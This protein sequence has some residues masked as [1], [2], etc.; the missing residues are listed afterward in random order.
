MSR[1]LAVAAATAAAGVTQA[2]LGQ[3]KSWNAAAGSWGTAGSWSPVGL[4]GPGNLVFIGN[5]AAAENAFL[6]MNVNAAIASLDISDGMLL[7]TDNSQLIVTGATSISGRNEDG[8]FAYP[9]RLRVSDGP[10]AFDTVIGAVTV[11]D[12]AWLEMD[13]G[14]LVVNGVMTIEDTA[15]AF[16]TGTIVFAGD[17]P[18]VLLVDGNLGAQIGLLTLIQ[19]GD[20]RIDLDGSVGGDKTLNYTLAMIDGSDFAR[21]AIDGVGLADAMDDNIWLGEGNEITMALDEGWTFGAGA[22]LKVFAHT[23]N[24][25]A[26][27]KGSHLAF[28]GTL[29]MSG[30]SRSLRFEAP[31]TFSPSADVELGM[32]CSVELDSTATVNGGSYVLGNDSIMAFDGATTLAGG[33]FTTLGASPNDGTVALNGATGYAGSVT[34]NGNAQQNGDASINGPTTISADALDMDG[35]N[36][37]THWSIGNGLVVNAASI[38]AGNSVFNG[39]MAIAGTF[40]GKLTVNLDNPTHRWTAAGELDLGGVAAIMTTRIEGSPLDVTGDLNITNRVQITADTRLL[41]GSTLSFASPTARLRLAGEGYLSG[42][43]SVVGNGLLENAASGDLTLG[44]GASIGGTDL[45]NAGTLRLGD[46]PGIAFV[47]GLTFEPT[48]T[49]VVELGGTAPGFEFDQLQVAETAILGG[50]LNVRLIDLGGGVYQPPIGAT[51]MIL[52]APPASLVGTFANDP[53]SFA[54]GN[55]YVWD[56]LYSSGGGASSNVTLQV[57][58]I[59]PCPADLNG[60]GEVNGADLA[61]LLGSWGRCAGCNADLTEDGA[62]D[63]AD[64]AILL[65]GWGPCPLG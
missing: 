21:I 10:S 36:G 43:A 62:V 3:V 37:T 8:I 20:G 5:T 9:S 55:V 13:G 30:S 44:Q 49:W 56:V 48:S 60:D 45:A 26:L 52:Q 2:S 63:G 25:P 39:S 33:T 47:G 46:S 51:F 41:S 64:L 29:D 15:A 40:L 35:S 14:T 18:T 11:S 28:N 6:N 22:T 23:A 57:A 42:S 38:D 1:A 7:E 31:V 19:D 32:A 59:I 4:P 53:V 54:P 17:Q 24:L 27:V 61:I 16:G 50:E 12:E 65:G 34:F 58:D